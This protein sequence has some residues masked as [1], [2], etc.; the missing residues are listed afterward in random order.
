[1]GGYGI[2]GID[3]G[4]INLASCEH[5]FLRVHENLGQHPSNNISIVSNEI[6]F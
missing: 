3:G 6:R 1:M 5:H 2:K 4:F